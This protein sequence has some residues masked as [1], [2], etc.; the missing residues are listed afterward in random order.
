[1]AQTEELRI[2]AA[3]GDRQAEFDAF[4]ATHLRRNYI[5]NLLYGLFGTTG[6]RLIMAPTFVPQYIKALSGSNTVVGL[7][8]LVG[9]ITRTTSPVFAVSF[10]EAR[11][12]RLRVV[13]MGLAMRSQILL[14]ALAGLFLPTHINIIAFFACY[15]LFNLFLGYQN[16]L[17][18]TTMSKV[19]PTRIRGTFIG[20]RNFL[21]GLTAFFVA[22]LAGRL[23][24]GLEFPL[25]YSYTYVTAFVLTVIGIGFF[26]LTREPAAPIDHPPAPS[27]RERLRLMWAMTHAD[28][29]YRNYIVARLL[30][31][32]AFVAQPFY[33]IY[34]S[35][36]LGLDFADIAVVT[37]TLFIAQTAAS[38]VWGQVADRMGFR[39]VFLFAIVL[40][41]IATVLLLAMPPTLG[42]M[43]VVF[44][45]VGPATGGYMMATNNLVLEF[46]TM[47]DRPQ[48]I[49]VASM[50]SEAVRGVAPFMGGLLADAV[51][52]KPVFAISLG[53]LL[54]AAV[55]MHTMVEEPRFANR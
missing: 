15:A 43:H 44:A 29:S 21:G 6:F 3:G 51:G 55:V 35:E 20:M 7:L 50:T 52:Y 47:E 32:A 5:V 25:S 27:A 28:P 53:C 48:R 17:Y 8:Q 16:V 41:L 36:S 4:V 42:L 31:T 2:D 11:Y 54:L 1:M 10:A 19:I 26:S 46:G 23:S 18:N 45:L 13:G 24:E 9:A 37:S 39:F 49:A 40:W 34:A 22:R 14:M 38:I 30:S 33:I 12:L